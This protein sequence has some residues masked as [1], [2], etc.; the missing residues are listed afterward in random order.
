MEQN[1]VETDDKGRK[2]CPPYDCVTSRT[3]DKWQLL[4]SLKF[5]DVL[6]A[7]A[8]TRYIM[9]ATG[10]Y[11]NS[12]AKVKRHFDVDY[13]GYFFVELAFYGPIS[14]RQIE[15]IL[16]PPCSNRGVTS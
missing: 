16:N 11:K 15:L 14:E 4:L 10:T 3:I 8:W 12:R 1:R 7:R 9:Q 6:S 5:D 13:H 2:I